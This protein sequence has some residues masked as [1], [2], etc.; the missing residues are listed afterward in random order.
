MPFI[1]ETQ[2]WTDVYYD[3]KIYDC[4]SYPDKEQTVDYAINAWDYKSGNTNGKEQ[5][6]A[7]KLD[8]FPRHATTIYLADYEYNPN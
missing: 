2:D 4:P 8:D 1:G 3:V 6:G 7:T 5:R